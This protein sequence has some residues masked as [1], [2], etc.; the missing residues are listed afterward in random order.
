MTMALALNA[1]VSD[2]ILR[3]HISHV[4]Y[5][6]FTKVPL[7]ITN[8]RV[9]KLIVGTLAL[10]LQTGLAGGSCVRLCDRSDEGLS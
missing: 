2:N 5:D 3:I 8:D 9:I 4:V 1:I 6:K 10:V 7:P